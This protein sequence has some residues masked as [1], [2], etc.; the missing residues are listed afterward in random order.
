MKIPMKKILFVGLLLC[1]SVISDYGQ[2]SPAA[3]DE[4]TLLFKFPAQRDTFF[5]PYRGNDVELDRLYSYV[6]KYGS[7]IR[8]GKLLLYVDGYCSSFDDT[9]KNLQTA[10]LRNSHVK[11]DL[12]VHKGLKEK[13]FVT[14]SHTIPYEEGSEDIVTV[15]M[16]I[17]DRLNVEG[18]KK[19]V[20]N[21]EVS[22]TAWVD[23]GLSKEDNFIIVNHT[24]TSEN[25][26]DSVKVTVKAPVGLQL[27]SPQLEWF[28]NNYIIVNYVNTYEG[29]KDTM[30]VRIPIRP[31]SKERV[32]TTQETKKAE[33]TERAEVV[34]QKTEEVVPV[35]VELPV[36]IVPS[37]PLLGSFHGLNVSLRTNMLYW[38]GTI[39][40]AGIAWRPFDRLEIIV[41]GLYNYWSWKNGDRL[42]RTQMIVPEF[43]W[44]LGEKQQW[45]WGG[46]FH[47]GDFNYKF[48][49][50]GYQGDLKGG[51]I[52]GGYRMY[53]SKIFDMDFYL[54]LGYT[55]LGY[56]TYNRSKGVMVKKGES[57]EKDFW[58]PTQ[59]GISLI[60]KINK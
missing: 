55:Q 57:V 49:K 47:A 43:R 48:G 34:E 14:V 9:N 19:K 27:Q 6:E 11:S 52:T 17:P 12:I 29:R 28:D 53:L 46:E 3:E 13:N 37:E 59:G 45:F 5:V 22:D 26:K 31:A 42:Y 18:K 54:G 39:P 44:Y 40:N 23:K 58:G 51:G 1:L 2:R 8:D 56:D 35:V 15:R 24:S 7:E 60:W 36:K 20:Q 21:T 38:L 30:T 50:N 41:N 16:R 4:K 10:F 25:N 32:T 33:E